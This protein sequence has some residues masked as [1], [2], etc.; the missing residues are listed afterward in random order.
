M[1][2]S[3]YTYLLQNPEN[4]STL[5]IQQLEEIISEFPY[6]QS[7]RAILLNGLQKTNSYKYN[8]TLKKTAA[9]TID[10]KVLFDFIT[11]PIFIDDKKSEIEVLENI[12]INEAETVKELHKKIV[13][14]IP[15]KTSAPKIF[16]DEKGTLENA[17]EIL[18]IGKPITFNSVEPHSFNEWMQLISKKPIVR[19]EKTNGNFS[20][21]DKFIEANPKIKP[22]DK[23]IVT[24]DISPESSKENDSL[25]TET[26]AKVY[27]EQKK[28]DNAIKAY[29]ILCLKYPEKSGFFAD[30]IKAIKILQRNKS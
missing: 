22:V 27:L 26:L 5:N 13:D 18:E 3:Q 29:R 25:M 23:N 17:K 15:P 6:F 14:S 2:S 1:N 16:K 4:I 11:S 21:I 12:K 30:R 19:E 9:Y 7:A 10:R 20:I 28:Y 8:S 24:R